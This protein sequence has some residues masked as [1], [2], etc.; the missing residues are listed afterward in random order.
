MPTVTSPGCQ[1]QYKLPDSAAG[2]VASC[3]C[4]KKFR[5]GGPPPTAGASLPKAASPAKPA[6]AAK[7]QAVRAPTA[8]KSQVATA[9]AP[10]AASKK[11][12]DFWD[13]ALGEPV[14]SAEPERP[15]PVAKIGS[16]AHAAL[17]DRRRRPEAEAKQKKPKARWGF[18]WGKVVGGLATFLI[19]GGIEAALVMGA[20]RINIWLAI[21]AV[22]GLITCLNGLMGEE[23]VW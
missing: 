13:S 12:D 23:G 19:A 18:D 8:S 4:G 21:I 9:A 15:K 20:G 7:G 1:K 6:P 10:E 11:D 3:K 17:P 22:G 14:K 5:V 2:Q 16:A